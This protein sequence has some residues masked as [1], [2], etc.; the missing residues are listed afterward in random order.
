[1]RPLLSLA[2]FSAALIAPRA[3]ACSAD[4]Y[5]KCGEQPPKTDRYDKKPGKGKGPAK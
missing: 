2:F 4:K 5:G 1:M 3:E